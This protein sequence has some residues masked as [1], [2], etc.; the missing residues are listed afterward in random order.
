M[1][2]F[3]RGLGR[4]FLILA[5]GA[6]GARLWAQPP[7]TTIRDTVFRADG[8]P[9]NGLVLIEWKTFQASNN[10]NIGAQGYT[11]NVVNGNLVVRLTPT[12]TANNAYY[13]VRYNSDG[14]FQF[15]EIWSVP[16]S[17]AALR[18]RDIRATLL[19][20]GI[21]VEIGRAHV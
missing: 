16:P 6:T 7:L 3:V 5:L 17:S 9:Y 4:L 19:P 10:A 20:G 14:Q 21:L 18:L 12:T 8:K 13:L 15:S 1:S 11:L 2:T